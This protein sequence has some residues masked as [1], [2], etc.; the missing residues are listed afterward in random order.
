MIGES[1]HVCSSWVNLVERKIIILFIRVDEHFYT[2][3]GW[4][5]IYDLLLRLKAIISDHT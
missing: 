1:T 3:P 5:L 2:V 4:I